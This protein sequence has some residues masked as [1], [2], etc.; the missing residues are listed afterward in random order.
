MS[1]SSGQGQGHRSKKQNAIL[2]PSD[3]SESMTVTAVKAS[4]IQS[5][6]GIVRTLLRLAAPPGRACAQVVQS[7]AGEFCQRQTY[8]VYT[9]W[10]T[11]PFTGM[12]VADVEWQTYRR[13]IK[14]ISVYLYIYLSPLT[15]YIKLQHQMQE[16]Y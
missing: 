14:N 13:N 3:L 15:F 4:P 5:L 7:E 2:P 8:V 11:S 12:V 6:R 9:M 16:L 10:C 1:R